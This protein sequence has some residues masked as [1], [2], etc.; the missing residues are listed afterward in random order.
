MKNK[1]LV[2]L[3]FS[4][5]SFSAQAFDISSQITQRDKRLNLTRFSPSN[6]TVDKQF[7]NQILE[8]VCKGK[9]CETE[10]KIKQD[11]NEAC[12]S[13][14]NDK[15]ILSYSV[16][17]FPMGPIS[18]IPDSY[19][20]FAVYLSQFQELLNANPN[21][22]EVEYLLL[23]DFFRD[24]EYNYRKFDN[25]NIKNSFAFAGKYLEDKKNQNKPFRKNVYDWAK[26]TMDDRELIEKKITGLKNALISEEALKN[27]RYNA[28]H[29][30]QNVTSQ[31]AFTKYKGFIFKDN[32]CKIIFRYLTD[33]YISTLYQNTQFECDRNAK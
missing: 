23:Q 1:M 6:L 22:N 20:G 30:L 13:S 33:E 5:F 14:F 3:T 2:A 15:L 28:A 12:T 8:P 31:E 32:E 18:F 26:A 27:Y 24:I 16:K 25:E 17:E 4:F 11:I 9:N 19:S 10:N 29:L 21:P 7:C